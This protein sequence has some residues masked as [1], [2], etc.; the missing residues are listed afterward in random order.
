MNTDVHGLGS[1]CRWTNPRFSVCIRVLK[2]LKPVDRN[3]PNERGGVYSFN[4]DVVQVGRNPDQAGDVVA[5]KIYDRIRTIDPPGHSQ[6]FHHML[7]GTFGLL[8]PNLGE[9]F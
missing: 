8:E 1:G 2:L 4:G 7:V 9:A 5:E 6:H 3:L